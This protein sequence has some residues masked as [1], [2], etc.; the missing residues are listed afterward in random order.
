VVGQDGL[1]GRALLARFRAL[2]QET[3]GTSRG[4]SLG[5]RL[6][7]P[8]DLADPHACLP[9]FPRF[10]TAVLCAGAT[11]LARCEEDP[12]GTRAVNVDGLLR[13]GADLLERGAR[14]VCLGT[15]AGD[16]EYA[17][18]KAEAEAGLLALD[19]GRGRV[20]AVRLGKVLGPDHPLLRSW[21]TALAAGKP[22]APFQDL[23]V[24]PLSVDHAV[25]ALADLALSD[26]TGTLHLA[27]A[28][29]ITYAHLG[30]AV[31]DR[32]GAP[33]GLV[34]PVRAPEGLSAPAAGPEADLPRQP[35]AAVLDELLEP[36]PEDPAALLRRALAAR[37]TGRPQEALAP[38]GRA[39]VQAPW[40]RELLVDLGEV[41]FKLNR[42]EEGLAC[43][44]MAGGPPS[45]LD[46][47]FLDARRREAAAAAWMATVRVPHESAG[48]LLKL[49]QLLAG[50][51]RFPEAFAAWRDVFAAC[52]DW[53]EAHKRMAAA[54]LFCGDLD[55]ADAVFQ[56]RV[57]RANAEARRLGLDGLGLRFLRDYTTH[58]GHLGF[59]DHYVKAR[60][61]GLRADIRPVVL[62]GRK[63]VANP[64]YLACW[65]RH[66]PDQVPSPEAYAHLES[67]A[68]LLEDHTHGALD[69]QGRQ[70]VTYTYGD[71]VEVQARW[72]R[73]G[74]PPLLALEPA[75]AARGEA[76]L[77][78]MGIPEGAWHV[79][80]HV[81]EDRWD[82]VRDARVAS[83][84]PAIQA[85]VDRGGWVVRMGDPAMTPLPPMPGVVDYALGPHKSDW[86]D[87][88]LWATGRFLVGT[89][90]GPYQVPPTFGRPCLLTN[91]APLYAP[92]MYGGDLLLPKR[93]YSPA[94]DRF[95]PY[96][97]LV[98]TRT[99][100]VSSSGHLASLGVEL[101][102]N[103]AEELREAAVEMLDR[104]G[105]CPPADDPDLQAA[106]RAWFAPLG[107]TNGRIGRDFARRHAHLLTATAGP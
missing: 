106:F 98:A 49:A 48:A 15:D 16:G 89:L 62:C 35:L 58:I 72:E 94:Q 9:A 40:D 47:D 36:R 2:G 101:V 27:G 22:I 8:L 1:L 10:R 53:V 104:T 96:R 99:G 82:R 73:E 54:F 91:V 21:L 55:L 23:P 4:P 30:A 64:S 70:R 83:Y 66:L 45:E 52:P 59:L 65:R 75:H 74:R 57:D 107:G 43:W 61:L 87:V 97:E 7:L 63:P 93:Y 86:M 5:E 56:A 90:S 24:A 95:L 92:A 100:L 77:R 33:A 81:R 41:Y 37:A 3:W 76:C 80:L 12:A 68:E 46:G 84:F 13:L 69:G 20:L 26:R 18:Q 102:D 6:T 28:P 88:Y 25:A 38:L 11:G 103:T 105:G 31:A 32:L 50:S 71:Y 39:L 19:R 67:L 29:G 85:I 79:G 60:L 78:A 17:R 14:V 44:R 51:G 34:R 42:S